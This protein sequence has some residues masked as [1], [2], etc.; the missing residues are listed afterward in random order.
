MR[1]SDLRFVSAEILPVTNRLRMLARCRIFSL[2]NVG[3]FSADCIFVDGNAGFSDRAYD[4]SNHMF[5]FGNGAY[6]RYSRRVS[7]VGNCLFRKS[8]RRRFFFQSFLFGKMPREKRRRRYSVHLFVYFPDRRR[9]RALRN[10]YFF[11]DN[12]TSSLRLITRAIN[13]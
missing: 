9:F 6:D 12:K 2:R 3:F 4:K 7:R 1:R 8:M 10:P 13:M 11:A 5:I